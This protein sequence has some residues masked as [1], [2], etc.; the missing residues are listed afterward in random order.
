L[1]ARDRDLGLFGGQAGWRLGRG[2]TYA[3]ADYAYD[4]TLLG[5]SPYLLA[6]RIR[7]AARWQISRVG[8]FAAYGLRIGSYQTPTSKSYSGRLHTLDPEV[9]LRFPMGSS[10]SVGYHAGRDLADLVETRSWEHGP[11]L[12]FRFILGRGWR[13]SGEGSFVYR[14][15]DAAVAGLAQPPRSDTSLYV[16]ASVE[17]DVGRWTVRLSA[18]DRVVS[19]NLP[20]YSYSRLTSTFGLSYTLGLF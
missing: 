2:D 1:Q 10:V 19:S 11:R 4:A 5:G 14:F 12:A 8:L 15:Y 20:G 18:G 6:H 17:K 3:F 9:S 13:A 16:G 7:A